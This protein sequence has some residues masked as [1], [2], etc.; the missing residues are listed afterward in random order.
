MVTRTLR[1]SFLLFVINIH[2]LG[3]GQNSTTSS[4]ATSYTAATKNNASTWSNL[5]NLQSSDNQYAISLI[6]GNK[7]PT[8]ELDAVG[9]GFQ[10]SSSSLSKYIP[11]N[12]TILVW[13]PVSEAPNLSQLC[14]SGAELFEPFITN[15]EVTTVYWNVAFTPGPEPVM[16]VLLV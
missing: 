4:S 15:Y 2:H 16:F 5:N 7:F 10:T 11:A 12:A 8:N 1:F 13:A 6:S 14:P 9:W 3:Y